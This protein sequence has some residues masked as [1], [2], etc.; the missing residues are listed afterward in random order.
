MNLQ[1]YDGQCVRILCT[2]GFTYEGRCEYYHEE[3]CMHAYGRE[4]PCLEI[5]N[6]LFFAE[7]IERIDSLEK[8][9]GPYGRFSAPFGRIEVL[10]A[11]DGADSVADQLFSDTEEHVYRMLCCLEQLFSAGKAEMLSREEV[12]GILTDLLQTEISPS[13]REKAQ[14]LLKH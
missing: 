3:Y 2:D 9:N 8:I 5:V 10:N 11:E 13:C 12:D 4:E 1:K 7:E 6:F 14:A